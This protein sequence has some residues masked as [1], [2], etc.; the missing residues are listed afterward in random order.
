MGWHVVGTQ[1]A[2]V[3]EKQLLDQRG[4][5]PSPPPGPP[6]SPEALGD[7]S[8]PETVMV[9][10]PG[11]TPGLL[12]R[13]LPVSPAPGASTCWEEGRGTGPLLTPQRCWAWPQRGLQGLHSGPLCGTGRSEGAPGV[14]V[15]M[16]QRDMGLSPSHKDY[17]LAAEVSSTTERERL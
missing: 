8:C 17:A 4:S 6:F 14:K 1:A 3:G 11:L 10:P 12:L 7:V 13:L 9:A 16:G 5:A 2:A 15:G